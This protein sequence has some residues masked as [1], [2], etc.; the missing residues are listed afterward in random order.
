MRDVDPLQAAAEAQLERADDAELFESST[1]EPPPSLNGVDTDDY[2]FH[3]DEPDEDLLDDDL[4]AGLRDDAEAD[5][6]DEVAEAFNARDLDRLLEVV[7]ADGEAPGLLGYDRANLPA[8]IEDLWL[9]RPNA[10]MTRGRTP[11][12]DVAVLWEHDGADWW[13]V[14]A[15]HVDDVT[16]GQVGVIEFSED[17]D[18][19]EHAECE[20]PSIEDMEQG[21]LWS[22]WEEGATD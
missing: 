19:L 20:P 2:G 17:G 7:A 22:E 9:R 16:D 18:L 10:F 12:E 13:K 21:S 5:A 4:D 11:S 14:A 3:L 6:L 15:V 8:A 1:D